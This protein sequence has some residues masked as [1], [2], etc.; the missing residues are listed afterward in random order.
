MAPT[1]KAFGDIW[2]SCSE[3]HGAVKELFQRDVLFLKTFLKYHKLTETSFGVL[4]SQGVPRRTCQLLLRGAQPCPCG[5]PWATWFPLPTG[6][7]F[8]GCLKSRHPL[9]PLGENVASIPGSSQEK[10]FRNEVD[11]KFNL[12]SVHKDSLEKKQ[13]QMNIT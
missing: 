1:Q 8:G 12:K 10:T 13:P 7:W 6:S 4:K 2:G 11:S 3:H 5:E 9:L